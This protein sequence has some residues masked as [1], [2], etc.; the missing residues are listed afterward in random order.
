[1]ASRYKVRQFQFWKVSKR[2]EDATEELLLAMCKRPLA[3]PEGP[4][5]LFDRGGVPWAFYG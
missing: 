4:F 2:D 1:M 3:Q 5:E